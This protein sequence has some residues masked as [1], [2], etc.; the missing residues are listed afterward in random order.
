[1]NVINKSDDEIVTITNQV[2]WMGQGISVFV[3]LCNGILSYTISTTTAWERWSTKTGHNVQLATKL[4][5]A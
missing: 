4:A 5:L 1:M 2:R 3:A